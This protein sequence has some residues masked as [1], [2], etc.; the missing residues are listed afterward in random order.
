MFIKRE[1]KKRGQIQL[2]WLNGFHSF[3]FASYFDPQW[4]GFSNLRVINEDFIKPS[5][6]FETHPH[7][8]MEIISYVIEGEVE[9]KDNLGNHQVVG[10]GSIQIMSA[11]KGILHSE[12]NPNPDIPTHMLQ[13]WIQPNTFNGK[14]SYQ[15]IDYTAE[16][17]CL[18]ELVAGVDQGGLI[19]QS[20]K[21]E[22]G[23][24]NGVDMDISLESKSVYWVQII[25][26]EGDFS[27]NKLKAGDGLGV[28]DE[29]ILQ[30][31]NSKDL[32]F[33]FFTLPNNS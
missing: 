22:L 12:F 28:K 29:S 19:K 17:N 5:M 4:M 15:K 11:G 26:G 14:A 13:L 23:R 27:G 1:A 16:E 33:L 6:G 10:P 20:M 21:L 7:K 18:T 32:E 25:K 24:Y 30:L 3:S 8:N 9:H 31:K 2:D